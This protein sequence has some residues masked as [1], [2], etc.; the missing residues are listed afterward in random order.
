[1]NFNQHWKYRKEKIK[2]KYTTLELSWLKEEAKIAWNMA[3][4]N[5]VPMNLDAA[6]IPAAPDS[7]SRC[8]CDGI[9]IIRTY[10]GNVC[11]ECGKLR[12]Q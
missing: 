9:E 1:M 3:L 7:E 2:K 12:Y 6:L 4:T 5:T 8:E 10:E 11:A